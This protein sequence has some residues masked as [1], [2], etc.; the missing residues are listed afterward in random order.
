[1]NHALIT[2]YLLLYQHFDGNSFIVLNKVIQTEANNRR[3]INNIFQIK[4]QN[5]ISRLK[6]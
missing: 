5:K 3:K 2:K 4:L 1:M 6:A